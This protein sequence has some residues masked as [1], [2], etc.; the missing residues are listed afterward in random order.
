MWSCSPNLVR[1]LFKDSIV[2]LLALKAILLFTMNILQ[3][4]AVLNW[5][6]QCFIMSHCLRRVS[7][8]ERGIFYACTNFARTNK[9]EITHKYCNVD[10]LLKGSSA[11]YLSGVAL[12]RKAQ[13]A[14]RTMLNIHAVLGAMLN[15]ESVTL[16]PKRVKSITSR[17]FWRV[18]GL[19]GSAKEEWIAQET[20]QE[21]R[22]QRRWKI[23]K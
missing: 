10:Q 15:P 4:S 18:W 6:N 14:K 1:L 8:V 9:S 19:Y 20:M 3:T 7:Y 13:D 2:S 21:H 11:S 23:W 5:E 16:T 12:W 22:G 17:L